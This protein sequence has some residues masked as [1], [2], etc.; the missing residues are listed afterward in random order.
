MTKE[1]Y[2]VVRAYREDGLGIIGVFTKEALAKI[3]MEAEYRDNYR[4]DY[5]SRGNMPMTHPDEI[6]L[7]ELDNY[8]SEFNRECWYETQILEGPIDA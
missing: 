6:T 1:V 7:A 5:A 4:Q 2:V 3:C 8:F